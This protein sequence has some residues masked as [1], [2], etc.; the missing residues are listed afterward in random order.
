MDASDIGDEQLISREE[1]LFEQLG[2]KISALGEEHAKVIGDIAELK[3]LQR[4]LEFVE[5]DEP[6]AAMVNLGCEFFANA[7]LAADA[8][9]LVHVGLGFFLEMDRQPAIAFSSMRIEMLEKR[10]LRLLE[11]SAEHTA[12]VRILSNLIAN[13]SGF[14]EARKL[15][16]SRR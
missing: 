14:D 10:A 12:E 15:R 3:R 9:P 11:L 8:R 5:G 2:S 13:L 6:A 7:E 1:L 16:Q 4:L